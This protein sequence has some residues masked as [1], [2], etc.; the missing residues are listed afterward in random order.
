MGLSCL[1]GLNSGHLLA[2]LAAS[3]PLLV[4]LGPLR[5][6]RVFRL[7]IDRLPFFACSSQSTSS[8]ANA[9]SP[10]DNRRERVLRARSSRRLLL[11]TTVGGKGGST[12]TI[13]VTL[14][15]VS[16]VASEESPP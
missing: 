6:R 7:G 16:L 8:K 3:L 2:D 15:G 5:I 13:S 9:L 11:F 12:C 14:T 10:V 4:I 1:S